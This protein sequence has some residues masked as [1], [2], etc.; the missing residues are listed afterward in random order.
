MNA[1]YALTAMLIVAILT[2]VSAYFGFMSSNS[3]SFV[4]Y[5]NQYK[6]Q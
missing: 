2:T 5:S 4:T 3:F 6:S 1:E